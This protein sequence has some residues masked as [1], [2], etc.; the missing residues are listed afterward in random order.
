MYRFNEPYVPD[1]A[2]DKLVECSNAGT[3]NRVTGICECDSG[4]EVVSDEEE[5]G[6]C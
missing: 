4:F 2:H 5:Y 3:C 1:I 6:I